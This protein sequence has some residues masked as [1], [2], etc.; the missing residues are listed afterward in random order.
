[1]KIKILF[2]SILSILLLF[3]LTG[4][5]RQ[6]VSENLKELAKVEVKEYEGKDL[7]SI[8]D[9]RENS[10]AGPQNVDISKYKLKIDGLVE[11][12]SD[13]TYDEILTNTKYTKVVRLDCVEGWS[14]DILWEGV[15]VKDLLDKVQVKS[16]ANTVIFYAYDG[17]STSLPLSTILDKDMIMAF[18]M[19]GVV[20]PPERGYPFQLVAED[21]LGYK[22]AKWITHIE[23]SSDENYKGYWESRGYSNEANAEN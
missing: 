3:T 21:K 8:V 20:L 22:W 9:F 5:G 14:V 15:L 13:F 18:K 23:L 4:C 6:E 11:N 2:V 19:N 17:Y 16:S 1:M 10:I 7:S 12:P